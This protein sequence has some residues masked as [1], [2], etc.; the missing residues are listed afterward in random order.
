MLGRVR[1]LFQPA[2]AS[3]TKVPYSAVNKRAFHHT[4][5][6]ET[7]DHLRDCRHKLGVMKVD[8]N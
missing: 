5:L 1:R 7:E 8:A 2:L 3:N 6:V 4:R